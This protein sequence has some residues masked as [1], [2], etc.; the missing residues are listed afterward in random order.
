L[1]EIKRKIPKFQAGK[2]A[3][4]SHLQEVLYDLGKALPLFLFFEALKFHL[5]DK[6]VI[7][8]S[9]WKIARRIKP[10]LS[11]GFI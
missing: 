11:W 8:F 9:A 7:V 1:G 10:K 6:N 2:H 3:L 5:D 4:K